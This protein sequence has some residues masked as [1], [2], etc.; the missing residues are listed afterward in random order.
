M[1]A[2]AALLDFAAATHRLAPAVRADT[3]RLL[4]DCLAIGA[5]GSGAPGANAILAVARGWGSGEEA[6]LLGSAERLPAA[7]AAFV[8]G[9]RIHAQEWDAVHE[10]AVVHAVTVV[11]A[12]VGAAIDRCGGCDADD[13]L[14]ALAVGVD[15]ASG[16][17]LVAEQGLRFFRPATSGVIGAALAVARMEGLPRGSLPDVLGLAYSQC[18][19]T[20]QAHTEGALAL[21][22]QMANA[23]RAAIVAVDLA[24][25]GFSGPHDALEGPFGYFR[26]F[27]SGNLTQYTKTLGQVWRISEVST[28]PYPCGRASHAA[29][30]A[31]AEI[32]IPASDVAAVALYVPPLINHLVGRAM[33]DDM[34]ASYARLCLPFLAAL[35]LREGRIDPRRFVP[36]VFSDRAT[37][38]LAAR[39]S[40]HVNDNPDPNALSPQ[41]IC[42]T[43]HD[44]RTIE[45]VIP[46]TLGSPL[47]PLSDRQNRAKLELAR[48]LAG[49]VADDRIFADPLSYYTD[50]S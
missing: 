28:K 44:G 48:D 21:P 18:A 3:I 36:D 30:G 23:A 15:V 13:V 35:M 27:E 24:S 32:A 16:L 45:R 5:A 29:L 31:L 40:I 39:V 8:N 33:T 22:F 26:L 46:H 7:T 10:P 6:R 20:M 41:R 42:V 50:P 12:A 37:R 14:A 19:G 1:T 4:A 11:A 47:A 43:T 34:S 25:A 2:T 38:D 49:P 17:G 9:Y